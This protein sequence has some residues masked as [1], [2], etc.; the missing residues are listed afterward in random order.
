MNDNYFDLEQE[1][2]LHD[3]YL[4][5]VDKGYSKDDLK[6]LREVILEETTF[7]EDAVDWPHE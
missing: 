6:P 5:L 2:V 4:M 1:D 7:G 3:A